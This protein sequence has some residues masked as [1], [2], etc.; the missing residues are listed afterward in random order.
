MK[1]I[2]RSENRSG[3][4][5]IVG[6]PLRAGPCI[7]EELRLRTLISNRP[8]RDTRVAALSGCSHTHPFRTVRAAVFPQAP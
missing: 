6:T 7:A 4:I 3:F 5:Q 1:I 8:R 2:E